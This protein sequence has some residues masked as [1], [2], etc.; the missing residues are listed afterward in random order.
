MKKQTIVVRK[1]EIGVAGPALAAMIGKVKTTLVAGAMWVMPWKTRSDSPRELRRS[2]GA[3][4]LT[5]SVRRK[6]SA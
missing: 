3:V 6:S 5:P 4:L 2:R 1:N